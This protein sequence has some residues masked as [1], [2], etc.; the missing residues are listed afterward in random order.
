MTNQG[1][2]CSPGRPQS[3]WLAASSP[4]CCRACLQAPPGTDW[5]KPLAPG[6]RAIGFD[7]FFGIAAN[8]WNGPHTFIENETLLGRIPGE[9][10]R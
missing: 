7:Y 4:A 1:K 10:V 6:P 8:A 3:C 5:N 9:E 2:P